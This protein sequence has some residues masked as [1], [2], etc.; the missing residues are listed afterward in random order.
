MATGKTNS[1]FAR[2][3]VDGTDLSGDVRSVGS[4][5]I[6]YDNIDVTGW[7]N[8]VVNFTLGNA[9]TGIS[10]FDAVFSN[11]AL[12]G[13]HTELSVQ[14]EYLVSLLIGIRAA[15][16]VGDPCYS[17]PLLQT[18]YTVDG[19]N[20]VAVSAAFEGPGQEQ[21][22]PL[23]V[24]G[25]VLSPES[26]ALIATTN[27]ASADAGAGTSNGALGYLHV[28]VSDGGSWSFRIEHSPNDSTWATLATFSSN[29]SAPAGEQ[30]SVIGT[31]DRYTRLV[32][33]RTSGTVTVAATIVRL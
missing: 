9:S 11:T 15:P 5:G 17:A 25:T 2:L 29:G 20:E 6:E 3:L 18:A 19:S 21:T 12:T 23:R 31:V 32:S 27:G 4:V 33:T 22:K 24:F 13:S 14:E 1:R 26:N 30:A 7:S 10:A 16:A 8:G 28:L